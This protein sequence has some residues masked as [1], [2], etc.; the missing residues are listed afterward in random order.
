MKRIL[1]IAIAMFALNAGVSFAESSKA[2]LGVGKDIKLPQATPVAYQTT[3]GYDNNK[4]YL[5]CRG[6]G[7]GVVVLTRNG[8]ARVNGVTYVRPNW[9]T[10]PVVKHRELMLFG[11]NDTGQNAYNYG[12]ACRIISWFG[13]PAF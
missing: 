7:R 9:T 10:W 11:L 12:P 6:G 13:R 8:T 3:G 5:D 1:A 2:Q 4:V